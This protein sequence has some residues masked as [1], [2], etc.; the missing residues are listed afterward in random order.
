MENNGCKLTKTQTLEKH[1]K[2]DE[3]FVK[4]EMIDDNVGDV[5]KEFKKLPILTIFVQFALIKNT[6][7]EALNIQKG[8]TD[9][10]IE[11]FYS[12]GEVV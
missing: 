8:K 12:D 10:N 4:F 6:S 9:I 1:P 7:S 5:S 11:Y 3:F 2:S